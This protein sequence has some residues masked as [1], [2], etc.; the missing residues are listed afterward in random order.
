M[1]ITIPLSLRRH[2]EINASEHIG[3]DIFVTHLLMSLT[4]LSVALTFID[5]LILSYFY[6][7]YYHNVNI[8]VTFVLS[9]CQICRMTNTI[10]QAIKMRPPPVTM[11]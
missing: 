4:V 3:Y 7:V 8:V 5:I 11:Y 2:L 10:L 1:V 6:P 9:A